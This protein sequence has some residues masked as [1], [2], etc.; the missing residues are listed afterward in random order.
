MLYGIRA[1]VLRYA[2]VVGPRL[3][4]GVIYDLLMKLRRDRTRLEVLGD[5][6]QVRSYIYVD[7]AVDAT[8][9][10]YERAGEGFSAFNVASEDWITVRD[11]VQIILR[12]L[13]IENIEVVYRSIMH[14]VGW[15]GDIK[16]IAL[17]ID[18][19]KALGFKP[20]MNSE[21]AVAKTVKALALEFEHG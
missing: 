5:G 14:G 9:I 17:R 16:R 19:L 8:M 1:V 13:G 6:T 3:R 7:D 20:S 11:V 2:N 18:R 21:E 10:A 15:P 12:E 4:H